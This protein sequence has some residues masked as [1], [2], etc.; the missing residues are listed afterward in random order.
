MN[1][2]KILI[3]VFALTFI[4]FLAP[5]VVSAAGLVPCGTEVYPEGQLVDGKGVGGMISNPCDWHYLIVG[6][7]NVTNYFIILGAAISALAFGYAGLLM[8]TA[9]GE[10]GKIEASLSRLL[11]SQNSVYFFTSSGCII[12]MLYHLKKYMQH[13]KTP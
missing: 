6:I 8:M 1:R 13:I 5:F 4:F 3:S 7:T 10:M 12:L 11:F 9:N 2:I